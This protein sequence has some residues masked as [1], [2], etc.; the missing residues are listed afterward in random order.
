MKKKRM[1]IVTKIVG[2]ALAL[3]IALSIPVNEVHAAHSSGT[4]AKYEHNYIY[5]WDSPYSGARTVM[6][7]YKYFSPSVFHSVFITYIN[8]TLEIYDWCTGKKIATIYDAV[9]KGTYV[10]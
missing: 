8:N 5:I 7:D 9:I 4:K 1:S 2:F 6:V 3:T 10:E